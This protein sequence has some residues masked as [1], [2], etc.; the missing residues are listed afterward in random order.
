MYS[1]GDIDGGFGA[2]FLGEG[3]YGPGFI[4]FASETADGLPELDQFTQE[5]RLVSNSGG[6]FNWLAGVFYFDESLKVDSFNY[7]SLAGGADDG[8]AYQY[9]DSNA[10][11]LFGSVDWQV[12]RRLEPQ[13]R[14][15][16]LER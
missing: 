16:V 15:A 10:W 5:F 12:S 3:N 2:V 7:D 9:Q 14:P 8:Y 13:G 6:P 1:R 11:A 4:Q